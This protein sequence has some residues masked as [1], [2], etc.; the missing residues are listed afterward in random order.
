MCNEAYALANGEVNWQA[1]WS[2][3]AYGEVEAIN[4]PTHSGTLTTGDQNIP[5]TAYYLTHDTM[6]IPATN[7]AELDTLGIDIS[8]IALVGGVNPTAKPTIIA[9]HIEYTTKST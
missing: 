7:V 8:R 4:A 6:V 1:D 9:L 3:A 5:A 2:L